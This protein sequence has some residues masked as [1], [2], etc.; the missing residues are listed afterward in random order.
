MKKNIFVLLFLVTSNILKA[1][2]SNKHLKVV[3]DKNAFEITIPNTWKEV[4]T[5]YPYYWVKEL[6]YKDSV[7]NGYL[8]IGQYKILKNKRNILESVVEKRVKKLNRVG[9]QKFNYK[10][11]KNNTKNHLIL[12]TTRRNW[13]NKKSILKHTTEFIK[14][15]NELYVFKYSDST[16]SSSKFKEE[17]KKITK[18]FKSLKKINPNPSIKKFVKPTFQVSFMSD[19]DITKIKHS[20]WL[21][22]LVFYKKGRYSGG[23]SYIESPIFSIESDYFTLKEEMSL[24]QLE[25]IILKNDKTLRDNISLKSR[26]TKKFIEVSGVWKDYR[27]NKKRKTIRYFKHNKSIIKVTY[28]V[29]IDQY[30]DFVKEKNLFFGSLKFN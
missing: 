3:F 25:F 14:N 27:K 8:N 19:W 30:N 1:Q 17:I 21:K 10:I 23:V 20:S 13:Q 24:K 22:S 9:Y 2:H 11:E 5:T 15:G 7:F 6:R 4:P 28:N 16:K 29:K 12:K 18:S 26:V